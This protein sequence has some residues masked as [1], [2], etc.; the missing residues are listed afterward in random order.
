M[1]GEFLGWDIWANGRR[2]TPEG[3]DAGTDDAGE[4]DQVLNFPPATT[5]PDFPPVN[6]EALPENAA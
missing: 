4:A 5:D 3:P 6:I 2:S 1:V